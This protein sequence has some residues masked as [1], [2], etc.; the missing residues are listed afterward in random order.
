MVAKRLAVLVMAAVCV[1]GIG[2]M[3]AAHAQNKAQASNADAA[4]YNVAEPHDTPIPSEAL[5][6]RIIANS[7]RSSDQAV[8][9]DVRNAVVVQVAQWLKGAKSEAQAKQIVIDHE[10]QIEALATKVV[11]QHGFTY[12]VRTDV[13]KVPFPTKIYGNQVYPAGEYEALRITLGSGQ[14]QN[15]WC[16]LF[17][18]LCFVDI[19]DGDA[20]PNTG[21]F[22]DLPPLETIEVPGSDGQPTQVQVRLAS[23]DYGEELWHAIER[24]L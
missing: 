18:P 21:G 20:V 22:P 2:R 7:D 3:M 9:L 15:W 5:R 16:V 14:G 1:V 23:V 13:G 10:P 24:V 8:K 19:A 17:P 6:L 4:L 11:R 12:A